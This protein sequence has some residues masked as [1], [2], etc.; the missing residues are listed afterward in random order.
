MS[1]TPAKPGTQT[2]RI[3]VFQEKNIRRVWHESEWWFSVID[4][5][6]VLSE[7]NNPNRY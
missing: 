5:V 7:S 6:G 2:D 3:V 1:K 4:V